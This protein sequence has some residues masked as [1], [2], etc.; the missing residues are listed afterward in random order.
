MTD[1]REIAHQFNNV[2]MGIQPH[3]EVIKR[4]SKDNQRVL[5]SVAHIEAAL[6]RGRDLTA[7]LRPGPTAE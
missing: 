5:D 2:L 6:K 4:A 3:V 1:P 7:Q